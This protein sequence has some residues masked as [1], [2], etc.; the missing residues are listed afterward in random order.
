MATHN[1]ARILD[2]VLSSIRRQNPPF[3]YEVIVADDSSSDGTAHVC[4]K[5]DVTYTYVPNESGLPYRNPA[6]ARNAS[7]RIA[8]G[9][10]MVC[11]SDDVVH[12]TDNA[13]ELL[14]TRLHVGHF[15][16]ATV[17]NYDLD[18][19][20]ETI[21]YTGVDNQRP[22]FFL[23]S[24]LRSDLY[25]VGGC[26]EDFV[27]PGSE[28]NWFADCLK[29]GRGLVPTFVPFV[30]GH[31]IDHTRPANLGQLVGPSRELYHQKLKAAE[32]GEIPWMASG[33]AWDLRQVQRRSGCVETE[34]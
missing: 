3:E 2:L 25:A 1:K 8:S 11:Q 23:G 29:R 32:A 17:V 26:C 13:I 21:Q 7:Y 18:Q 16:I 4:A 34:I 9:D 19:R 20:R 30:K 6:F 33:G 12:V 14:C 28:D 24:L 27:Y 22:L 31:H 15:N 5:H 10:I